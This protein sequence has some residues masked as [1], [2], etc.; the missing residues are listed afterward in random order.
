M[1]PGDFWPRVSSHS[2]SCLGGHLEL[3]PQS[4]MSLS[5]SLPGEDMIAV[6]GK[7]DSQVAGEGYGYLSAGCGSMHPMVPRGM[8][9][10]WRLETGRRIH[11]GK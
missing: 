3:D 1:N 9:S 4:R 5:L 6:E 2:F 11:G 10:F 8:T 7:G